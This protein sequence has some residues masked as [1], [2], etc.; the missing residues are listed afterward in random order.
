MILYILDSE[1]HCELIIKM[2]QLVGEYTGTDSHNIWLNCQS[3]SYNFSS[4]LPTHYRHVQV[5]HYQIK[6]MLL[7]KFYRHTP[8]VRCLY[9]FSLE[10]YRFLKNLCQY[11]LRYYLVIDNKDFHRFNTF[12]FLT[13]YAGLAFYTF[14]TNVLILLL[15]TTCVVPR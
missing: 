1:R 11:H 14:L 6:I 9:V 5:H 15:K 8:V 13:Y 12:D 10:S 4:L 2:F 3:F 7:S